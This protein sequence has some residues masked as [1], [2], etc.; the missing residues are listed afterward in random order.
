MTKSGTNHLHGSVFEFVRNAAFDAR[1]FFDHHGGAARPH[2]ALRAQRIRLHQRGP[3]GAPRD[4][5]RPRPYVLF[6]QYQGFRQIL[7]TTQVLPVP[8]AEERLGRDSTAFPGDVLTVPVNPKIAPV[9]ARYPLPNDPQEPLRRAHLRH[10]VEGPNGDGPVL[11]SHRSQ[12]LGQISTVRPFQPER[13][14]RPA[15]E[16]EPDRDRPVLRGSLLR[17]S[18]HRRPEVHAHAVGRADARNRRSALTRSTPHFPTINSVQ[19]GLTFADALYESFNAASGSDPGGV[20]QPLPVPA[21]PCPAYSW[22]PLLESGRRGPLE[23]GHD[24][25]R[26]EPE[27]DVR[28]RRGRRVLAGRDSLGERAARHPTRATRCPI[29]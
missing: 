11:R 8:T 2:S 24:A 27:R 17:P 26:H 15:H 20:R 10:V 13:R 16:P 25:V 5:R 3:S 29:R 18:A 7:G 1:N 6:R 21:G 22:K 28:I 4:L 23:P 19:P 12:A 9:L 14:G